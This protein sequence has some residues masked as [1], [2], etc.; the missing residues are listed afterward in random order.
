MGLGTILPFA[1]GMARSPSP[2]VVLA[3]SL[4]SLL[5]LTAC[6]S[7]STGAAPS[8]PADAGAPV[9]EPDAAPADKCAAVPKASK[10]ATDGA[11][12][13]GIVHF[14][15]KHV[16]AT[17]PVLRIALRHSFTLVAGEEAIGGRLHTYVSI[18]IT[19]PST[20][21]VPFALDMCR[22]GTG[23]FSEENGPFHV[24][25]ILDENDNNDLDAARTN[26]DAVTIATPD[27]GEL[28][29]MTTLDV[30]CHAASTCLDITLDCVD[31][32]TC[33]TFA[34][35]TSC[36]KKTPSCKSADSFCK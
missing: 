31:G 10:C 4:L 34:P 1:R 3:S 22:F 28:V 16:T 23:M 6:S 12:V 5:A 15:A 33:T 11:W 17:K 21:E 30:S 24:V 32:A 14:D 8:A 35:M 36:T 7:A 9:E 27:K 13:R 26:E 18:P 2:S 29:K 19:D 25:A 20:G